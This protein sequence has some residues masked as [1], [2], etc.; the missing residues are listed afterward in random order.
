MVRSYRAGENSQILGLAEALGLP[1]E[2]KRLVYK[3]AGVFG[4]LTRR[5]GLFGI[6]QS[7]SS[8]LEPPWPRL[9][10][11]AG[12][13]NEPV[14]RALARQSGGRTR[15]VFV[16]RTWAPR[17][18]FDLIV[19]TPQ[20]RLPDGPGVLE[21]LG[22]LHRVT[23]ARLQEAAEIW[24]PR[25]N[26]E[27]GRTIAVLIGGRSGPVTFGTHAAKRLAKLSQARAH[28]IGAKLLVTSSSRTDPRAVD[29]LADTL[30]ANLPDTSHI[31]RFGT[32][33]TNPYFGM[34][35]L[36]DE[37][38][39]TSDSIAMLSEACATGKPVWIFDLGAAPRDSTLATAL[40]RAL[41][42]VG[43]KRLSRD[44]ALAHEKFIAA[45]FAAWLER[46]A[47]PAAG[48]H[49]EDLAR[50]VAKVQALLKEPQ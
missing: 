26:P 22:T 1:F 25:L 45:G 19:T 15:L 18:E 16:G 10:I 48:G 39:V 8:P 36:A 11:S 4:N 32:N 46:D 33:D 21:N 43:P 49:T 24:R 14:C 30:A 40:Y 17:S 44:L 47:E 20:Y 41:M 3:R 35:A 2:E 28:K 34:L 27:G 5:V 42:R 9:I 38:I 12:L 31:H 29:I 13:R 37:I 23:E 50:A 6:R 7:A